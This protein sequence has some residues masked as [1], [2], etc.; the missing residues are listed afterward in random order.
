MGQRGMGTTS[1]P[2]PFA[3]MGVLGP[4]MGAS[5][6]G[7]LSANSFFV[8]SSENIII[9]M[10]SVHVPR[11]PGGD[12]GVGGRPDYAGRRQHSPITSSRGG[13][14]ARSAASSKPSSAADQVE[15]MQTQCDLF[16]R[17]IEVERRRAAE[18][19]KKLKVRRTATL[20]PFSTKVG[21]NAL[22]AR[23]TAP[24]H[25]LRAQML[26]IQRTVPSMLVADIKSETVRVAACSGRAR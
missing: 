13:R 8:R 5:R 17:R 18:L 3:S 4:G 16:T 15:Y 24:K 9:K 1:P 21:F 26:G 12:G 23:K 22:N 11:P 19:D 14:T 6:W 2:L 25:T 7:Q 20:V 10:S